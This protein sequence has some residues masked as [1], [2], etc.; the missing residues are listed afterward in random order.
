MKKFFIHHAKAIAFS[1]AA[2]SA[3]GHIVAWMLLPKQLVLQITSEGTAG[4]VLPSWLFFGL[5]TIAEAIIW[6]GAAYSEKNRSKWMVFSVL[7]LFM[8]AV[9][10]ILN[11]VGWQNLIS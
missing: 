1:L 5:I 6:I 9:T 3:M 7:V 11:M 8:D 10:I 2:L 4:N